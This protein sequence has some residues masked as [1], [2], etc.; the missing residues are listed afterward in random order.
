VLTVKT[1]TMEAMKTGAL[2]ILAYSMCYRYNPKGGEGVDGGGGA[3]R[4]V[5]GG[6]ASEG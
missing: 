1:M 4:G 5:D 6:G 3:S 2:Y